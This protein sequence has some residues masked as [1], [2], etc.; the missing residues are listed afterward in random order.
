VPTE[1]DRVR[2]I[3]R[4]LG[5]AHGPL[6]PPRRIDPLE[7]LVLTI[8]SQNTS[9]V[10]RDRA[11]AGMRERFPTWEQ[12]AEAPLGAL[13]EAIR[14]GGLANTK[15]PRI[16]QVLREIREREGRL[17]LS[18]MRETSDEEVSDYLLSLPGVGRKTAACVLA[19]SLERPVIPV[20]THVLRVSRRLG[21]VPEKAGADL[22]HQLLA[23]LVPPTLRVPLHVGLIRH[24]RA[25]CK[26][27]I[28]RCES[29]PLRDLCPSAEAFLAE[30]KRR[31]A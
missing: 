31:T 12:V 5:R 8:L 21:L 17:D 23:D 20:D 25:I 14:P 24:G 3:H 2:T 13:R 10:N 6:D 7:E 9:D 19:F 30:R 29:C 15:A 11:Y 28:P 1:R 4:R 27:G 16:R 26:A 18:W 22:A